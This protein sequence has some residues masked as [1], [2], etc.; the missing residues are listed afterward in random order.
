MCVCIRVR[1]RAVLCHIYHHALHDRW[2]PARDL[3]MMTHLQENIVYADVPTQVRRYVVDEPYA[4]VNLAQSKT[5]LI[6]TRAPHLTRQL[7]KATTCDWV[8]VCLLTRCL[9]VDRVVRN[10]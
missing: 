3:M 6:Q 1:T 2:V 7:L 9:L 10:S 4:H 8:W 5:S